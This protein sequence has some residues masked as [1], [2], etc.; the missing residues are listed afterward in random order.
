MK[1]ITASVKDIPLYLK[2]F[3][4]YDFKQITSRDEMVRWFDGDWGTYWF[5]FKNSD[6]TVRMD[7]VHQRNGTTRFAMYAGRKIKNSNKTIFDGL[8]AII[9]PYIPIK[10]L[11]ELCV[12][13]GI[14][15]KDPEFTFADSLYNG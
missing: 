3:S 11:V 13:N 6:D 8:G 1:K 14:K 4:K 9:T 15:F 2:K 10:E 5:L 7:I 12:D